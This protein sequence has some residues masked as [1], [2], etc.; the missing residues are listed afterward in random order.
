MPK[1]T[2]PLQMTIHFVRQHFAQ[3][4]VTVTE[5]KLL[6]DSHL[7]IER[8]VDIVIEGEFDGDRSVTSIEVIEH[9]RPASIVWVEQQIARHRYLPTNRLILLSKSGFSANALAAIAMEGGRVEAAVPRIV[10]SDGKQV[11]QSLFLDQVQL[12]PL[13]GTLVLL[14]AMGELPAQPVAHDG[15]VYLGD[16]L[17]GTVPELA[18]EVLQIKWLA[19]HLLKQIHNHSE[20]EAITHFTCGVPLAELQYQCHDSAT[21]EHYDI[22]WIEIVGA[23]GFEQHELP[24]AFSSLGSR[25]YGVAEAPVLGHPAIWVH[26]QDDKSAISKISGRLKQ[27]VPV[28]EVSDRTLRFPELLDIPAPV[29]IQALGASP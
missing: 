27:G 19:G 9:G 18:A 15:N 17:R 24:F 22:A 12:S 28:R 21:R 13:R 10:E 11:I 23:I 20:R 29:T 4:N 26:T 8:E 7:G 16:T 1:R 2:T 6:L 3:P 25:R 5:S 14:T